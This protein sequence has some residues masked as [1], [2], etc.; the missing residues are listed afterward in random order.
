MGQQI[1]SST[2]WWILF[3]VK[4]LRSTRRY[5]ALIE[6]SYTATFAIM[7]RHSYRTR[8]QN[9]LELL[10]LVFGDETQQQGTV[11]NLRAVMTPP[12][13]GKAMERWGWWIITNDNIKSPFVWLL[14]RRFVRKIADIWTWVSNGTFRTFLERSYWE[15]LRKIWKIKGSKIGVFPGKSSFSEDWCQWNVSSVRVLQSVVKYGTLHVRKCSDM[16]QKNSCPALW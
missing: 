7:A 1:R 10:Q 15:I 12:V 16:M 14:M 13:C 2:Q 6:R 9:A 8:G 4:I 11:F 3:L 5:R